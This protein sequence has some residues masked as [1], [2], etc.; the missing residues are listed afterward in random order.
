M[1]K[2]NRNF[3]ECY[4]ERSVPKLRRLTAKWRRRPLWKIWLRNCG[5]HSDFV[6]CA[7]SVRSQIPRA[8]FS[9]QTSRQT[10]VAFYVRL[11]SITWI[12]HLSLT[13]HLIHLRVKCWSQKTDEE[14]SE[15]GSANGRD[16]ERRSINKSALMCR[17]LHIIII[18]IFIL[19][20]QRRTLRWSVL[21]YE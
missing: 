20:E 9:W 5:S 16:G 18:I 12:Y 17:V 7:C 2:R 19:M 1:S 6:C 4:P 10:V 13:F 15:M 8:A 21:F 11:R 14:Q 3:Y